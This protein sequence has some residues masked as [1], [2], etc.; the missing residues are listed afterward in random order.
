MGGAGYGFAFFFA[1]G[2]GDGTYGYYFAEAL[3]MEDPNNDGVK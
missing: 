3:G 2:K 1:A